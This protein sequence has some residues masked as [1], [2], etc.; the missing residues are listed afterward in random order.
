M[1]RTA[2]E[3]LHIRGRKAAK[4]VLAKGESRTTVG[5]SREM[6]VAGYKAGRKDSMR[7]KRGAALTL[8]HVLDNQ[9]VLKAK[10]AELRARLE[11]L[12][13]TALQGAKS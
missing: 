3:R 13:A 5:I 12:G 9:R 8:L 6:W 11:A 2:T 1:K 7:H 10:V 4:R